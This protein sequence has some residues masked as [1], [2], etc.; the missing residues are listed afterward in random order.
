MT[1]RRFLRLA[2]SVGRAGA[3]QSREALP[4]L[5]L[6]QMGKKLLSR[7]VTQGRR[8]RRADPRGVNSLPKPLG[9][10]GQSRDAGARSRLKALPCLPWSRGLGCGHLK[11]TASLPALVSHK[12]VTKSHPVL[13]WPGTNPEMSPVSGGQQSPLEIKPGW[14][15]RGFWKVLAEV[16]DGRERCLEMGSWY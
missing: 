14:A 1:R 16:L 5:V 7:R 3:S 6:N 4:W 15:T 9:A 2:G 10:K 11:A 13:Q 12:R 8:A